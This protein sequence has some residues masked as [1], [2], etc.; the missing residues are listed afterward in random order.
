MRW[1]PLNR[2]EDC[3]YERKFLIAT[4]TRDE[5][6]L[7]IKLHPAMFSEIYHPRV[8]NN[9]YFDSPDMRNYFDTVDGL[10]SRLK[11]RIRW[12]G[13]RIGAIVNPVLELKIK[14]GFLGKKKQFQLHSFSIDESFQPH[15]IADVLR[16]STLP[17]SLK[18]DL[19][20]MEAVQLNSYRRK[21]F[22]SVDRKFRITLD[23]S[24][25]FYPI[26]SHGNTVRQRPVRPSHLVVELKYNQSEDSCVESIS[27]HFPFRIS[28]NSKYTK[29]IQTCSF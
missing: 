13:N 9:L 21:Y 17:H 7:I 16:Q 2:I 12:Y 24:I 22:Q 11:V 29:G 26:K 8:V 27:R 19:M 3:R 23:S 5:V 4:L 6:E 14:K 28:K 25:Q 20:G 18:L 10:N 15:R 1:G